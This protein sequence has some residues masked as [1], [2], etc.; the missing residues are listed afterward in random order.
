[1]SIADDPCAR[2]RTVALPGA[3]SCAL[4]N[5]AP[6]WRIASYIAWLEM[7]D[8]ALRINGFASVFDWEDDCGQASDAEAEHILR[9]VFGGSHERGL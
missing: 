3:P 4:T 5:R 2:E 7:V 6:P 1:V 8:R 9:L